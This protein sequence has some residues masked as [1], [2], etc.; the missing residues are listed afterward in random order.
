MLSL[1]KLSSFRNLIKSSTAQFHYK[2]KNEP[3]MS[4]LKGSEERKE[5]QKS[6]EKLGSQ[7][8][9]VP[10]VIGDRELT[11]S[12]EKHQVRPFDHKNP[13]AKYYHASASQLAE[14]IV[15][16]QRAAREWDETPIEERAEVF[17]KAAQLI[18]GKYRYDLLAATMLGQGKTV[19]Q[20]EIDAACEMAD[21]FN[22]NIEWAMEAKQW[23]PIS[24]GSVENKME[25]RAMEGFWAAISPFNF[26]AIG[27]H[28]AAAPAFMG[29]VVL[30]KPS[31]TAVLSNYIT[32]KILRE[33]GLPKGV[34]SFVPSEG[35][36]FGG[37]VTTHPLL[38]GV[39]FTGS[40]RTFEHIWS[41]VGANI[42]SYKAFPRLIGEC[43][44]KN[45]HLVHPSAVSTHED[46]AHVVNSTVLSAFEYSG[47]KCSACSRVYVPR[48]SWPHFKTALIET[49][50]KLKL[51][52]PLE[53]D[54]FLSSVIDQTSFSKIQTYIEAA[55][56]D[57]ELTIIKGGK[58]DDSVG[59][60]VEA[61]IIEST[62]PLNKILT[63]E[64]FGPVLGVH[65]YPDNT[66]DAILD[67]VDT[68][69][70][71]ALTGSVF[72]KDESVMRKSRQHLRFSAGNI[73]QN[74]KSTGSVV[75]QQPFGG[76]RKSGTN[77]KAGGP[78]YVLRFVNPL[79]VKI[80]TA[81]N[82]KC[83]YDYMLTPFE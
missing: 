60:N 15:E 55:K 82:T 25:W 57:P 37:V 43:G 44:G 61:T 21:F 56:T 70:P 11:S 66:Y 34:I 32:F 8:H 2:A 17:G 74:D 64:I 40:N 35:P 80:Q 42:S 76:A 4:F 46:I 50:D 45:F 73:Y 68:S 26:T 75:S 79:S 58:C 1:R 62:N 83:H 3:V 9:T 54:T 31:D 28:L 7:V 78:H 67:L 38:A 5:L 41:S 48:S 65:V 77:D 63:H 22:F 71:Y 52:S 13:L 53:A 51:G 23:Q 16:S 33:A 19:I 59:Y 27:G 72:S 81:R 39:N 47:Q 24:V 12:Q 14:A 10:I 69:T 36:V 49:T 30:W 29:N 18:T 20:A 6:L